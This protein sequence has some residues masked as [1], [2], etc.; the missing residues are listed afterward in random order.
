MAKQFCC[1]GFSIMGTTSS[2]TK[3]AMQVSSIQK[4][5]LTS[6]WGHLYLPMGVATSF[7]SD[8]ASSPCRRTWPAVSRPSNVCVMPMLAAWALR[9]MPI[10]S[11]HTVFRSQTT[12]SRRCNL[13]SRFASAMLPF[14]PICAYA[15]SMR[16]RL[17]V[18]SS[19][20]LCWNG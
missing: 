15:A 20:V 13:S 17:R 1:S 7:M 2:T 10:I 3:T 19:M 18:S 6:H 8:S 14:V 4:V 5:L 11:L 16:W 12:C 9:S